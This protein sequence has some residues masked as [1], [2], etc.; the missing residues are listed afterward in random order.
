MPD[1]FKIERPQSDV[2]EGS[3]CFQKRSKFGNMQSRTTHL[4]RAWT[5]SAL[6]KSTDGK[7]DQEAP[8]PETYAYPFAWPAPSAPWRIGPKVLSQVGG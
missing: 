4:S 5:T 7:Q 3:V 1:I 2:K 6:K 8:D